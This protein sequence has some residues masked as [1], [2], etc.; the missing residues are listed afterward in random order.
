MPNKEVITLLGIA[1]S[2]WRSEDRWIQIDMFLHHKILM[3]M[4]TTKGLL[5]Q[6]ASLQQGYGVN[7]LDAADL[8][9]ICQM[10]FCPAKRET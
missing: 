7:V 1:G 4:G 5:F 8:V 3:I 10:T 2:Q 9:V 6:S